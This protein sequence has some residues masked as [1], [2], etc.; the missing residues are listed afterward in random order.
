MRVYRAHVGKLAEWLKLFTAIMPIRE[1]YSKNVG[2]FQT[3][4]A[5]LNEAVHIW[6]YRDLKHRAEVR[7]AALQDADWSGFV[8]KASPLLAEMRSI[9]LVPTPFSKLR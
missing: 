9:V 7:A 4:V 8:S 3:E 1:K 6:A 5:Q 2:V